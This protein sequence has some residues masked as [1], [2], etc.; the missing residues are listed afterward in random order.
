LRVNEGAFGASVVSEEETSAYLLHEQAII[1]FVGRNAM[2]GESVVKE[3]IEG[4]AD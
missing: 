2:G 4:A 3:H 1:L